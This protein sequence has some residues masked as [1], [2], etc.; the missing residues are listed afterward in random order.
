MTKPVPVNTEKNPASVSA[1]STIQDSP[2][3]E[4]EISFRKGNCNILLIAPHGRAKNDKKTYEITRLAA[5]QL[6]CYAFVTKI[7][8]K[9]LKKKGSD[10]RQPPDKSKKWINLNRMDQVQEHLVSE[11]EKPL[12]N[13][14]DEIIKEYGNALVV[15]IHGIKDKNLTPNT[16]GNIP[17]MDVLIGV[18]QGN[19]DKLTAKMGT[20]DKLIAA[21]QSNSVKPI[22]A[23][24]ARSGS[25]YCGQDENNMNQYFLFKEYSLDKVES[26]QIEIRDIGFRDNDNFVYTAMALSDS[27]SGIF[28]SPPAENKHLILDSAVQ[29]GTIQHIQFDEIDMEN[30]QF[31]SRLDEI[32]SDAIEFKRLVESV[33]KDG[34]LVNIIVRR[35]S[36]TDGKLYQLISGFRRMTAL[37]ESL[38]EKDFVNAIVPARILEAAITDEEAYRISFTENLIRKDLSLWE[39][40]QACAGIKKRMVESGKEKGEINDHIA[41]LLHKGDK[42]VSRYLK[43]ASI[44]NKDIKEAVHNGSINYLDALEIGEKDFEEGDITALLGHLKVH[45]KSTRAFKQFYDNLEHCCDISKLSMVEV[46]L[47]K[48]ADE[49]LSLEKE[50]L[51]TRIEHLH[52]ETGK[53]YQD[54]LKGRAGA[55]IKETGEIDAGLKKREAFAE[56]QEE[57]KDISKSVY[58]AFIKSNINGKFKIKPILGSTENQVTVT[59]TAPKTEIWKAI[60][61]VSK[62]NKATEKVVPSKDV[63]SASNTVFVV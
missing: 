6:D 46:L 7:Y 19:P 11:F 54:I 28:F 51:E 1:P 4:S 38:S 52:N 36:G 62:A 13:T 49:F 21:L 33:E 43:L 2:W 58:E 44:K 40:A 18:G 35:H 59:I 10:E 15:W 39:I 24:L 20:V 32:N 8:R 55:L 60:N 48:N 27:L 14:V 22:K 3:N 41:N 17:G 30:L 12:L 29:K 31:M 42:T 34:V 61:A 50:E 53:D 37:K 9:P 23:A 47:C 26:I 25:N 63:S 45:P 5:D 57:N 56:F 16:E